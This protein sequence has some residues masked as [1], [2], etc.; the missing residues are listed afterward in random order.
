MMEPSGWTGKKLGCQL[1]NAP[2]IFFLRHQKEN[3]PRPV[4]KKKC[5]GGSVRMDADLLPPAGDGWHSRAASQGRKRPALGEPFGPGMYRDTL[6][7]SFRCRS[8][9]REEP[10]SA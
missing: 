8:R 4:E 2:P 3:V 5:F 10:G 9:F 1:G 6:C 7:F